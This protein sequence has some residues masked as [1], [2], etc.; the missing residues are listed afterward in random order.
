MR[1]L[2]FLAGFICAAP[3]FAQAPQQKPSY[4]LSGP[5]VE[6]LFQRLSTN[7]L[8]MMLQAEVQHQPPAAGC[9]ETPTAPAPAP[10]Q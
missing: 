3:A 2:F 1:V 8:M 6:E 9:P 10:N 7:A 5:L 4:V